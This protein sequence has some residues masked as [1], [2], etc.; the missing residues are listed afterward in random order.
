MKQLT[1]SDAC[2]SNRIRKTAIFNIFLDV[3]RPCICSRF[4]T[5]CRRV[6][7]KAYRANLFSLNSPSK[8]CVRL[9]CALR[10]SADTTSESRLSTFLASVWQLAV[11]TFLPRIRA[12]GDAQRGALYCRV[13]GRIMHLFVHIASRR[14]SLLR[15]QNRFNCIF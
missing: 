8:R 13:A 7:A 5:S 6:I 15:S 10:H 14:P 4:S 9:A 3:A 12:R 1:R 11:V 2:C